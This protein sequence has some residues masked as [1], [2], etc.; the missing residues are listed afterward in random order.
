M[1]FLSFHDNRMTKIKNIAIF[2][3]TENDISVDF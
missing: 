3:E 1:T 2:A